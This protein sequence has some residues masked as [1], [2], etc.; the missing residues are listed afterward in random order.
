MLGSASGTAS[1]Q[2]NGIA[3]AG[4]CAMALSAHLSARAS[5]AMALDPPRGPVACESTV[6]MP[7]VRVAGTVASVA[8]VR[9]RSLLSHGTVTSLSS[10]MPLRLHKFGVVAFRCCRQ[11]FSHWSIPFYLFITA[12]WF[13]ISQGRREVHLL[14]PLD[15]A[16]RRAG[17]SRCGPPG[18]PRRPGPARV[19]SRPSR[20]ILRPD[21][22][23]RS[24]CAS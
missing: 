12:Y 5:R 6:H 24:S 3:M 23:D 4:P 9:V 19:W 15:V 17:V 10:R 11:H 1:R 20:P 2:R 13:F 22:D 14:P 7:A 16:R 21:Q 18:P 8:T